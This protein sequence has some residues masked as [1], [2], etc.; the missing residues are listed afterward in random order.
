MKHCF[1]VILSLLLWA[2]P[3]AAVAPDRPARQSCEEQTAPYR[4]TREVT[5]GSLPIGRVTVWSCVSY[6]DALDQVETGDAAVRRDACQR[7][8]RCE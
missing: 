3:V 6:Q 2:T 7:Y 1:V 8:G 5:S 4:I